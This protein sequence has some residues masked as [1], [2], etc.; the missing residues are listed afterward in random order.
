MGKL[1]KHTVV[2]KREGKEHDDL[3]LCMPK[4]IKDD[5]SFQLMFG[6]LPDRNEDKI[7]TDKHHIDHASRTK[8]YNSNEI[9]EFYQ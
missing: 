2:W 1:T 7:R 9:K 4:I 6:V 8:V 3:V 5:I